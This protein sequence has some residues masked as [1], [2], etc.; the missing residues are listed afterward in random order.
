MGIDVG[1]VRVGLAASDPDGLLAVPV[2]TLIRDVKK[3]RDIALV[4]RTVA[5]REAVE[6]FVGLPRNLRGDETE[7]T[8]MA[9]DY[10]QL[11]AEA[12]E[13]AGLS[14]PVKLIDERLSTVSAHQALRQAG[15]DTRNHRKVVDQAAAVGILQHALD[16]QRSLGRS[17]GEPVHL[18]RLPRPQGSAPAT[19]QESAISQQTETTEG[20]PSRES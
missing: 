15:I 9:R 5:E 17:V 18:R 2:R 11:L 12:L 4:V 7:S 8:R 10:A 1:R 14:V 16:M 19:T 13:T 20:G 6:V 3:D